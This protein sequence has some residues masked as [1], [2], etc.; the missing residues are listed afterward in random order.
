MV[1]EQKINL[2][3]NIQPHNINRFSAI[4]KF[5]IEN[6]R[7]INKFIQMNSNVINKELVQVA[8][9]I[10]HVFDFDTKRIIWRADIKKKQY[11]YRNERF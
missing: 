9:M 10:P 8:L 11:N 5:F 6:K 4:I 7:L 3:S 2:E 1:S